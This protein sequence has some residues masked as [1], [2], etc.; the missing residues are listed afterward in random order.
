MKAIGLVIMI[1]IFLCSTGSAQSPEYEKKC[2]AT[3]DGQTAQF[4]FPVPKDETL[5]WDMNDT[6]ENALEYS[7]EICLEQTKT[8]CKFT[9][10]VYHFKCLLC[11]NSQPDKKGTISDLL[12]IFQKSVWNDANSVQTEM[13]VDAEIEHDSLIIRITEQKTFAGLFSNHPTFAR[14]KVKTPYRNLN[15][16]TDTQ[17]KY[18][19]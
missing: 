16:Q 4:N 1:S 17:I 3:V 10:G 6:S 9:F 19:E 2:T 5:A 13:K 18:N 7:W 8:S 14:C 12:S 11:D 15:F